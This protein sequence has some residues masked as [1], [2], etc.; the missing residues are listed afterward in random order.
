MSL[1][2]WNKLARPPG[3]ALKRIEA[4]RLKGKTDISPQWRY[5]ILT[6]TFGPCGVG[7]KYT[8][9]RLWTEPGHAGV[10]FAFA[11]VSVY[12][13]QDDQWG[14]AIPG[15]GGHK[16]L[17]DESKG[18]HNN[19][20]AFKMATTDA[21]GVAMKMLGVAADIYLGNWD[22]SKYRTPA[23]EEPAKA[24]AFAG[25]APPTPQ[26]KPQPK[27]AVFPW[28]TA[29][30]TARKDYAIS[31]LK[32]AAKLPDPVQACKRMQDILL[33]IKPDD[34]ATV[35]QEAVIAAEQA[36]ALQ[37]TPQPGA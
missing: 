30:S 2:L 9:D 26:P 19:D 34:L 21:L 22:G 32:E 13:K 25:Q 10:V 33:A 23:P 6:D 12:V 28:A 36:L 17:E 8:I 37:I 18:I 31:R 3:Q 5:Q 24:S 27:P 15:I 1:E 35:D 16:L 7:W 11:T 29:S 20:E 14:E 4:G